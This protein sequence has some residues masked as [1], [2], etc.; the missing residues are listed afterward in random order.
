MRVGM[1]PI[2]SKPLLPSRPKMTRRKMT[3]FLPPTEM[4]PSRRRPFC[5]RSIPRRLRY[6]S[7]LGTVPLR[8][9]SHG[10]RIAR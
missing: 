4:R 3:A 8:H 10:P 9:G 2:A 5:N 1:V 7:R 6:R